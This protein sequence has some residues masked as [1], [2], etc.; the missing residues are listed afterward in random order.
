MLYVDTGAPHPITAFAAIDW[1]KDNKTP[2]QSGAEYTIW[3]F[4]NRTLTTDETPAAGNDPGP[5]TPM[6]VP[7][8]LASAVAAW[9]TEPIPGTETYQ[10]ITHAVLVDPNGTPHQIPPAALGITAHPAAASTP[11]Q[12]AS[13]PQPSA[14]KQ[15]PSTDTKPAVPG[16]KQ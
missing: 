16:P 6:H 12:P 15:P 7:A 5:D 3:I 13:T 8:P 2:S 1:T 10:N 11:S 9:A 14:D 4:S